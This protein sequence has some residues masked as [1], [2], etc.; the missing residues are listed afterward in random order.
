MQHAVDTPGHAIE[1]RSWTYF[2]LVSR[3]SCHLLLTHDLLGDFLVQ[4]VLILTCIPAFSIAYVV[5]ERP[6]M[7]PA[8][9]Q[10]LR[11]ALSRS[12]RRPGAA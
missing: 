10:K 9:P 2:C 5:I 1:H 12:P 8:C 7:D 11:A 3:A 6:C 4:S